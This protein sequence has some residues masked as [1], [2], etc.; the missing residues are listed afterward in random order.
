MTRLL[1]AGAGGHGT[2]VAEAAADAG[3]WEEIAFLDDN[4]SLTSV[5]DFQV[6]GTIEQLD[7]FANDETE[8]IVAIGDN[9]RRLELSDHITQQGIALA[10][11]IHPTACVS[12][13]AAIAAGT[14]LCAGVIVNARAQVGR[15]CILNTG[16]TIDHDCSIEDGAHISPGANLS[17]GVIVGECAWIG[18][19]SAIIGGVLIGKDAIVGAGAAVVEDVADGETVGGVPARRLKKQ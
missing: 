10:T 1:I 2:V 7:V 16:C 5:L 13:S 4:V 6:V 15:G 18:T 19:G 17:G 8:V 11:V 12:Q 9:R 3:N 14:V